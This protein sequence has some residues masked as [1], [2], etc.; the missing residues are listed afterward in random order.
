MET[1]DMREV[2]P[3]DL[4][5]SKL[6]TPKAKGLDISKEFALTDSAENGK[7]IDLGDGAN[8]TLR[9]TNSKRWRKA[10]NKKVTS[11]AR[12]RHGDVER[13]RNRALAECMSKELVV[14]AE[15]VFMGG[16]TI[17]NAQDFER[18]FK[19]N[20]QF[21]DFVYRLASDPDEFEED[22]DSPD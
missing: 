11:M 16:K 14:D 19:A 6:S 20:D 7:K 21:M 13:A 4:P 17:K 22:S 9:S 3:K 2:T 8:I 5:E 1:R 18:A 15:N 12:R 10:W